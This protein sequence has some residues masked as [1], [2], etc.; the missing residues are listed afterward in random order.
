[1]RI[2][3]ETMEPLFPELSKDDLSSLF[4]EKNAGKSIK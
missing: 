3:Y 2:F 4:E 1:M